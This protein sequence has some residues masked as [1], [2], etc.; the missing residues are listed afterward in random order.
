MVK[1]HCMPGGLGISSLVLRDCYVLATDDDAHLDRARRPM[2]WPVDEKL[3]PHRYES[4]SKFCTYNR[5]MY[6][7]FL[8]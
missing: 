3:F 2:R 7:S 1:L 6:R 4:G 8:L 5:V